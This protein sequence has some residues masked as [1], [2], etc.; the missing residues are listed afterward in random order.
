MARA[1]E[2]DELVGVVLKGL[3][4]T[5]KNRGVYPEDALRERFIKVEQV[6]RRLALVPAEGARLPLYFLSFLQAALIAKPD[7]PISKDELEDKPF[8]FNKLDTYDI[9]NR[10][11]YWLDRGDLVKTV[12]YMNLLQ[13]A[14]RKA[15]MDWLN[16][17]RLLLETQQAAST[18][19]AHASS[20]GVR[21][22]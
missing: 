11:R 19:M 6:S 3:P 1:A 12:Q 21:F 18:L 5:A 7:V 15:A 16:E 13:G 8:D 22:L 17:A 10:A 4:E 2:G 14:S 9:L 20:S